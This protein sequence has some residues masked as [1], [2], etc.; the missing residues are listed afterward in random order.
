MFKKEHFIHHLVRPFVSAPC[1]C[2]KKRKNSQLHC[3][4][5][6]IFTKLCFP[7]RKLNIF[8][9]GVPVQPKNH[10]SRKDLFKETLWVLQQA[11]G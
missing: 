4:L 8:V 6:H 9:I 1:Y 10:E 3:A 11:N 7:V 2:E 5:A